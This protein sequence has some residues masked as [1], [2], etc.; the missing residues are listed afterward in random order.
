M[1][2]ENKGF[3]FETA[4]QA[5]QTGRGATTGR[6]FPNILNTQERFVGL[7][8]QQTRLKQYIGNSGN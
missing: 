6:S 7:F 8:T 4:L 5:I 2:N 1:E 3:N